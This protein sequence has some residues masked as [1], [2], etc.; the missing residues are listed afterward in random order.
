MTPTSSTTVISRRHRARVLTALASIATALGALALTSAPALAAAPL[1][2]EESVGNVAATTATLNAQVN[3]EGS[4]TSAFFEYGTSAAYGS[5]TAPQAL[6][7]GTEPALA[8]SALSGL[9]ESTE[10]HYRV[11]VTN[12][13]HETAYGA[14]QTFTTYPVQSGTPALPDGRAYELVS[15]AEKEGGRGGVYPLDFTPGQGNRVDGQSTESSPDGGAIAYVG[16]PF[17]QSHNGNFDNVYVSHREPTQDRW[18]TRDITPP[19]PFKNGSN[20]EALGFS[21]DL[22]SAVFWDVD[23]LGVGAP[24]DLP[25]NEEYLDLWLQ[26]D[27]GPYQPLVDSQAFQFSS[28]SENREGSTLYIQ[29]VFDGSSS[30]LSH[31]IFEAHDTLT[32]NAA[33]VGGQAQEN[34]GGNLYEWVDGDVSLVNELPLPGGGSEPAGFG[35]GIAAGITGTAEVIHLFDL[36]PNL[37]HVISSDGSRVFWSSVESV[38]REHYRPKVLYVRE[39]AGTPQARTVQI[40]AGGEFWTAS[41]DGSVVFYTKGGDLYEYE[42]ETETKP[43]TTNDLTPGG[44]VQGVMG[45]SEDGSYVYFAAGGV[46]GDGAAKGAVPQTCEHPKEQPDGRPI[47]GTGTPC[48]L[49]VSHGGETRYIATLSPEDNTFPSNSGDLR[50]VVGDWVPQSALRTARVSPNGLYVAFLSKNN[51]TGYNSHGVYELYRYGVQ[52]DRLVCASCQPSGAPP[53]AGGAIASTE[54]GAFA[55]PAINGIY[56]QRYLSNTGQVF[57]DS[58]EA[59]VPQDTNGT[60]DVYEYEHGHVYLSSPGTGG[61]SNFADASEN[62]ENVFFTTRDQLVPQDKDENVDMYDARVGGGFPP[63]AQAACTGTGCQG[64]PPAPPIFATPSS[65]TFNGV[66]N[67]PPPP[68]TVV[69]PKPKTVKCPKGK[70]RNKHGKCLKQK[71]S[72]KSAAKKSA[73]TNRRASR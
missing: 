67:F 42:L 58:N 34:S 20:N 30:D 64:V 16:E 9:A 11:V 37:S 10:Y 55:T 57:F 44:E 32:S 50:G 73:H 26:E 72:K 12:A 56:G 25:G 49:Y 2:S 5:S 17:Y 46:L 47:R 24:S 52:E 21:A 60:T 41:A 31:V 35:S 36:V 65:V 39:D 54:Y 13:S 53:T 69:K 70:K 45:A 40:A 6:G 43:A 23:P 51:I 28:R 8:D 7:E 1:V 68:P 59:L 29:P 22:S 19:F 14:D 33:P 4:E 15:P 63:P 18:S 71:K 27:G 62:G 3:P 38:R 66:G 48:N 61:P